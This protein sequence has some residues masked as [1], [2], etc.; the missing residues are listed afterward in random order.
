MEEEKS[1]IKMGEEKIEGQVQIEINRRKENMGE[2]KGRAVHTKANE[3]QK[4]DVKEN[5]IHSEKR[6]SI[7]QACINLDNVSF[8]SNLT[9]YD[10]ARYNPPEHTAQPTIHMRAHIQL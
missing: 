9:T 7:S 2:Q 5:K 10:V 3:A 1:D 6:A 4:V 8:T